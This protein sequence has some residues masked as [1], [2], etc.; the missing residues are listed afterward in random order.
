MR[1]LN[2]D[3]KDNL[4]KQ[5]NEW[6]KQGV[7]QP[8]V[9]PWVSPLVPVKKKNGRIRWVTDLR[10]LNKQTVKDSY[11][12]TNTQ[13]FLQSLQSATVFSSLDTCGAYHTVRIKN[14]VEHVQLL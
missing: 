10:E 9:N 11:P 1:P 5:I 3:Q 2:P 4:Q 8:S 6:M 7:I 14:E 13:K 12:L